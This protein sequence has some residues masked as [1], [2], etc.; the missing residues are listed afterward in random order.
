[1][2]ELTRAAVK[3][4]AEELAERAIEET[5]RER[6]TQEVTEGT[7]KTSSTRDERDGQR[8]RLPGVDRSSVF[9]LVIK[10]RDENGTGLPVGYRIRILKLPIFSD[11]GYRYFFR[12]VGYG[13]YPDR[14]QPDT[15]RIGDS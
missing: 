15:G 3:C 1:L 12:R 7:V 14:A 2:H 4:T 13:S 6:T 11:T 10:A 8:W 9:T 5:R